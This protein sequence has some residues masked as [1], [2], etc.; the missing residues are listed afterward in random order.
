[1]MILLM[2]C[3]TSFIF[4]EDNS[5][6]MQIAT[7]ANPGISKKVKD[8]PEL[9][10]IF[11]K[12]NVEGSF[13]LFDSLEHSFTA[14]NL[15]RTN[16]RFTPA[17]T[18]KIP[19]ALIFLE[20]GVVINQNIPIEK[21]DGTK[22]DYPGWNEDQTLRS[23]IKNS[24]VWYFQTNAKKVGKDRM[25]KYVDLFNYGNR[26]ISKGVDKFWLEDGMRISQREQIDF[27]RRMYSY[28]LP[29]KRENIDIVKEIIELER[30][31]TYRLCGKTG[32]ATRVTPRIGWL[33]GYVETKNN[34]YFFAT[35][36]EQMDPSDL[37][38]SARKAITM[39]ILKE[40]GVI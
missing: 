17:S 14:V 1:M 4:S 31:E 7:I 5:S 30:T 25:Q 34:V 40:L 12:Y 33:I 38:G 37:F 35:N 22:Y 3:I 2:A 27:L 28:S 8:R 10:K 6:T 9:S 18:F 13:L 15:E 19:N 11:A 39:S 26:D 21:W 23:A 16:K 20:T 32:F 36:I 24:V 29:V